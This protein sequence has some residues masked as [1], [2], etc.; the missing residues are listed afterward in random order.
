MCP[1]FQVIPRMLELA[2]ARCNFDQRSF[3]EYEPDPWHSLVSS[4]RYGLPP[5]CLI[6]KRTVHPDHQRGCCPRALND[7]HW[8]FGH[9][10]DTICT[11]ESETT[12]EQKSLHPIFRLRFLSGFAGD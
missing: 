3:W 1:A 2:Q 7:L 12:R 11:P 5:L 4:I 6:R 10:F 8:E 9:Y